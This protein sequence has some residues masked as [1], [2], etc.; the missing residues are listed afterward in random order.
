MATAELLQQRAQELRLSIV[1]MIH[2]AGSGHTGGSL[3]CA[4]I[5]T[6]L[7]DVIMNV[8]PDQPAWEDRDRFVLSKGHG[9][10]ALYAVLARNGFFDTDRLDTLRQLESC[11]QGH[12][13]MFK[14]PGVEMSTGSL[15]MGLSVGV[16]MAL[17]AKLQ[18]KKYRVYVLCGDGELNEGQNWEAMMSMAKWQLDNLVLIV[19]RNHV[20]L[21]GTEAQ[22]MPLFDLQAKLAAF[23]LSVTCCDGHDTQ[24]L[25]D[26][27]KA[28]AGQAC[29]AAIIA[30]TVKGKGVSFMEGKSEWHGKTIDS[31]DY[32]KAVNE[33]RGEL[34]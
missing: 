20:Q 26:A 12:P 21:D 8:R 14:L 13:C 33:I 28:V 19:D 2:K 16:G 6:V 10:P 18:G 29:P 3:S 22:V 34:A 23:G 15:G 32:R 25:L 30:E 17:A 24:Q 4:E 27:F 1:D 7:Y 11:L 5:L 31:D 9:A